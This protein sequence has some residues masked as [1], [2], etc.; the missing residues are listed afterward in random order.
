MD[1]KDDFFGKYYL[2]IHLPLLTD[3]VNT[4]EVDFVEKVLDLPKGSTILDVHCGFGRHSNLLALRGYKVTGVDIKEE[5]LELAR[6]HSKEHKTGAIFIEEDMKKLP[7]ENKFDAVLNLF[8]SFGYFSD[9]ENFEFLKRVAKSLKTGG[10]FLIDNVSREWSI[11]QAKES[12]LVWLLY[13]DNKVFLAKNKFN[14]LTGRWYSD[15]LI[16][17]K[18]QTFKQVQDIRLYTYTEMSNMLNKVGLVIIK[19]FG[20]YNPDVPYQVN[21]RN[22]V[23]LA[24]KVI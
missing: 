16:V 24:E 14:I 8:T 12:P 9:E 18:G 5:F 23:L 19:A 4:S 21:S 6:K 2:D 20:E 15:Q 17:D 22:M 13:P 11:N 1:W 7:F 10:K 3:D